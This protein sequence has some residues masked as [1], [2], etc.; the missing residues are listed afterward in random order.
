MTV[1]IVARNVSHQIYVDQ[2]RRYVTTMATIE[3]YVSLSFVIHLQLY[4]VSL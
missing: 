3:V 4:D 2:V 1:Q